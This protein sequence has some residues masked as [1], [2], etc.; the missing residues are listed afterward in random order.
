[1]A[2]A[3][4]SR[5][6]PA[7]AQRGTVR[8]GRAWLAACAVAYAGLCAL[9]ARFVTDDAWIS[10]RYAENV[11]SGGGFGFN[12]GGPRV[13]GFSNPGL[14]SLEALG[15]A[16]GLQPLDVARCLGVASGLALLALLHVAGP[17]VAGR[18]ATR[19]ALVL[20]AL[21]PP[22][23]VWAGGG[24][25]TMPAALAT[26]AGVL[27]LARPAPGRRDAVLAGAAFAVL[28]WLRPEGL[29]IGLAVVAASE[30]PALL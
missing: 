29:A 22:M 28:P 4:W 2:A 8:A 30:A 9:L 17:A 27:A 23:A 25:E 1:M 13:E 15:A 5:W 19:A 26:T 21:F 20:T 10:A 6:R 18:T 16:L 12:P 11:A 7:R 3:Q 24:L 14:V